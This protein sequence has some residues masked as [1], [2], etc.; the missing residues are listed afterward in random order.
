MSE[1]YTIVES[2]TLPSKGMV[3]NKQVN[4]IVS[5]RSMTTEDEMLRLAHSDRPYKLLCDIIDSC[6]VKEKPGI[7]SYDMCLGDYQF[8]LHKIRVVTYGPDYKTY[9]ICPYCGEPN[10]KDVNLDDIPVHEYTDDLKKYFEFKLPRTGKTVKIRLQ[11]PR[12]VDDIQNKIKELK[13]K[14]PDIKVD[15]TILYTVQSLIEKVDDVVLNPMELDRLVRGLPMADTN[16]IL[17]CAEKLN[18]NI[19]LDTNLNI[20]CKGCGV[21]YDTPFR[22][23]SEFFGPQIDL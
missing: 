1:N 21:D 13:K 17:R 10:T 23:T 6:M 2:Y 16:Y 3:Y 8:L 4:P 20:E 22:I 7:S 5:L 12:I 19:G 15:P 14:S 18:S 11:T 9:S